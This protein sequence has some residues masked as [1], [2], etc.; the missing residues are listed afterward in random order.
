MQQSAFGRED[1]IDYGDLEL[2]DILAT[3]FFSMA[4][5]TESYSSTSLRS[6]SRV[7]LRMNCS[8]ESKLP[9]KCMYFDFERT[10][11]RAD[12]L[13]AFDDGCLT[14]RQLLVELDRRR[15]L[16]VDHV[17]ETHDHDSEDDLCD[18]LY[19]C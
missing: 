2:L 18:F 9:V 11:C 7:S 17:D 13:D 19:H 5:A 8:S 15:N 14:G 12:V 3:R 16:L 1:R 4:I 6:S 10:L